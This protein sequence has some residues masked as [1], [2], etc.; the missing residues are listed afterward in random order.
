MV[1]TR[2][3]LIALAVMSL[4]VVGC[5]KDDAPA[6]QDDPGKHAVP[7]QKDP[8]P[9]LTKAADPD[10]PPAQA[11]A[12]SAAV[13]LAAMVGG[14]N[15][16]SNADLQL[17]PVDSEIVG[18]LNVSQMQQSALWKQYMTPLVGNAAPTL[19]SIKAA[20]GFDPLVTVTSVSVGLKHVMTSAPEGVF[21]VHGI[22]KAKMLGP[23]L[24]KLKTEMAKEHTK[25]ALDG[26]VVTI[27]GNKPGELVAFTFLNDNTLVGALGEKGTK[28]GVLEIAQG[29]S[30]LAKSAAFIDMYSR[31]NTSES[32]WA[33]A[34]G[35]SHLLD[36]LAALVKPRAMYG[37]L[38]F[39]DT[40]ALDLRLR[41]DSA[42]QAK[43]LASMGGSQVT[44]AKQFFNKLEV[45]A[46]GPDVH[47]GLAMTPQQIVKVQKE[48]GAMLGGLGGP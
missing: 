3:W 8:K 26:D 42:D 22:D 10:P 45:S 19:K 7:D 20:C 38:N 47:I 40:I 1:A 2:S 4:G 17:L 5:K 43:Q 24:A 41:L 11:P 39:T 9:P 44:T 46:D 32:V 34:N 15:P 13:P 23:C 25:V 12:P 6:K 21:V 31:I 14:S 16:A 27:T 33:L 48:F 29:G 30:P 28:A 18:G 36:K 37:S 35:N